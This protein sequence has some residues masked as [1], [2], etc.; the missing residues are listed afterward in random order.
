M[1]DAILLGPYFDSGFLDRPRYVSPWAHNTGR[2][3]ATLAYGSFMMNVNLSGLS[4][5]NFI[6]AELR[7]D[8]S[9][10]M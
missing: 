6:R 1:G 4:L 9:R 7:A 5:E 10:A 3:A 2:L 8:D